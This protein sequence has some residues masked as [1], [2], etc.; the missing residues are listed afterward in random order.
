[1]LFID[2][3]V[4]VDGSQVGVNRKLELWRQTLESKCFRLSKTKTK[5]MRCDF[6]ITTHEGDVSLEGQV[7]RKKDAFRYM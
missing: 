5:Y 7:V 1:M 3:V 6:G 2:Y 4:L